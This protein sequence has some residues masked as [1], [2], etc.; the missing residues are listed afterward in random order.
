[1]VFGW[2]QTPLW[3]P[4][5]G[6]ADW[7]GRPAHVTQE[8][9]VQAIPSGRTRYPLVAA[10]ADAGILGSPPLRASS[11][12]RALATRRQPLL[13]NSLATVLETALPTPTL[14]CKTCAGPGP[15]SNAHCQSHPCSSGSCPV[16]PLPAP[17]FPMTAV[18]LSPA[19]LLLQGL[20]ESP[21]FLFLPISSSTI[22]ESIFPMHTH[23]GLS[24]RR[25]PPPSHIHFVTFPKYSA[26]AIVMDSLVPFG[27]G[28]LSGSLLSLPYS[29]ALAMVLYHLLLPAW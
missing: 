9:C 10:G 18:D 20:Q 1:M 24:Q 4:P 28:H 26:V 21:P 14:S 2:C 7:G 13:R 6:L 12:C 8:P 16:P 23:S 17:Q 25:E 5:L 22:V 3:T 19:S 11:S 15:F 29:G 27:A